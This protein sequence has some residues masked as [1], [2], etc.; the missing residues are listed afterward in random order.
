MNQYDD[1]LDRL[2]NQRQRL[3]SAAVGAKN[4]GRARAKADAEGRAAYLAS[5]AREIGQVAHGGILPARAFVSYAKNTGSVYFE[6]VRKELVEKHGLEVKTGFDRD[7]KREA[8]VLARVLNALSQVSMFVGIWTIEEKG[9]A[10]ALRHSF[11]LL[12]EDGVHSDYWMKT[13]PADLHFV[14]EAPSFCEKADEALDLLVQKYKNRLEL[15]L[16][17]VPEAV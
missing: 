6:Y 12:V 14:F 9:M 4:E 11:V 5:L 7:V 13:A 17:D 16:R 3:I 8:N 1:L 15:F 2:E 10:L